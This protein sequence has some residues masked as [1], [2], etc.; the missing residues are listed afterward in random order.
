[1]KKI[2]QAIIL[3][4]MCLILTI[5]IAIQIKTVNSNGS[6]VSS[7]QQINELKTQVLKMKEKYE[8]S[9]EKLEVAQKQLKETRTTVTSND[10]ELKA[11]EEEIKKDN[12]LLGLTDVTGKGVTITLEDANIASGTLGTILDPSYLIIHDVDIL[13]VVNELKNAGAE[14]IDVNGQR[15]INDSTI[16][17]DGNVIVVNGKKISSPFIINAIGY[18][19]RLATL[20]RPGGYL[21]KMEESY[22]KTTLNKSDKVTITKYT[23]VT[24][25][26]YAKTVK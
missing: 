16:V 26:K 23:G 18:P 3:G 4:T 5:G 15:I 11:L 25:F 7:N 10:E 1:M 20:K 22:I 17:C 21:P 19:E 9:Y 14:A 13:Q 6:A 24:N 2:T 8:N 12:I